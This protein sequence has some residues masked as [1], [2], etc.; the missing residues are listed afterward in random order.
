MG[1]RTYL[2]EDKKCYQDRPYFWFCLLSLPVSFL[3]I[4]GSLVMCLLFIEAVDLMFVID[5]SLTSLTVTQDVFIVVTLTIFAIMDLRLLYFTIAVD[6]PLH[7]V[8]IL[9]GF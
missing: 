9:P 6:V 5:S 1:G 4:F 8:D 7:L 2:Q 3:G